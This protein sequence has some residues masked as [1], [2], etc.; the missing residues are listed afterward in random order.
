MRHFSPFPSSFFL[1]FF[2]PAVEERDEG[3]GGGGGGTL[4]LARLLS[5]T[6]PVRALACSHVRYFVFLF[7]NWFIMG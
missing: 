7:D 5:A 6:V 1:F 4:G 3:R 2:L